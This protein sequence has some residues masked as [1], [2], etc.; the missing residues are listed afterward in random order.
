VL[1]LILAQ[2]YGFLASSAEVAILVAVAFTVASGL[3][4]LWR[5]GFLVKRHRG[6]ETIPIEPLARELGGSWS[7]R[8]PPWR[9]RSPAPAACWPRSSPTSPAARPIS[10]G[11]WSPMP[12]GSSATSWSARVGPGA[13][14]SGQ[15]RDRHRHGRRGA[16]PAGGRH[17][18]GGDRHRRSPAEGDAK[19]VGLTYVAVADAR[20]ATCAST[21]LTG[22]RWQNRRQAALEALRLVLERRAGVPMSEA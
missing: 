14:G 22:N 8:G 18:P 1:L 9:W 13:V 16:L 7:G 4:Y 12:T 17:R 10:P 15:R 20:G 3:D 19:P 5:F 2:P 21:C 6:G 11:A